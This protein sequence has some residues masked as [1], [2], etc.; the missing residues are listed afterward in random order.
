MRMKYPQY[1][2]NGRSDPPGRW[3]VVGI[4][5]FVTNATIVVA[6]GML[7]PLNSEPLATRPDFRAMQ[8]IAVDEPEPTETPLEEAVQQVALPPPDVEATPVSARF[9]DQY[10]RR[11]E[12]ETVS[13]SD[14]SGTPAAGQADSSGSPAMATASVPRTPTA[15]SSATS[16]GGRAGLQRSSSPPTPA[17]PPEITDP[18]MPNR[19]EAGSAEGPDMRTP[20]GQ[21]GV[22]EPTPPLNFGAF[23]PGFGNAGGAI[24]APPVRR[25]DHLELPEGERTELNSVRSI[26]WSFFNRMHQALEREWDPRAVFAIHDP[27]FQLYGQQDRY[28]ILRVTLNSEGGLRQAFI[29]RS[30]GLDFYDDEA[31]RTFRAAAPFANVPEGL[32]DENG[33][34]TFTF[35]FNFTFRSGSAFVRRLDGF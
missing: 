33:N 21:D 1:S 34:A 17:R 7:W 35:G 32:K 2:N 26:Y 23:A 22:S 10:D 15:P 29:E 11:T 3:F 24:A 12:R 19:D 9:A 13:R 28:T 16:A 27:S 31:I 14:L 25:S 8:L 18:T 6:G 4:L 5:A 20:D 30:S